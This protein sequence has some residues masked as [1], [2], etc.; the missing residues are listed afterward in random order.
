MIERIARRG[1]RVAALDL[2]GLHAVFEARVLLEERCAAL[3]A[4]RADAADIR[5]MRDAFAGYE[6]MIRNREFRTLVAMDRQFH[7]A[8]AAAT[9]N[10]SLMKMQA[11]LHKDAMRFWYF[12]LSRLDPN[13]VRADIASH[14]AIV[15]AIERRNSA[16]AAKAMREV[17][18]HFP[19]MVR[20][21][22]SGA[23]HHQR[24]GGKNERSGIERNKIDRSKS[25][26]G[27]T[28]WRLRKRPEKAPAIA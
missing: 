4:E 1:T 18:G 21:F 17:L 5:A 11:W 13:E 14:L 28:H 10:P 3:A 16:A 22:M 24:E 15:A 9:K 2:S 23:M 20:A 7:R 12:G 19:D 27:K 8:L 26:R 25:E 6:T